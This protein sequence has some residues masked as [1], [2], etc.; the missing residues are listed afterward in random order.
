LKD[1]LLVDMLCDALRGPMER[2]AIDQLRIGGDYA[3]L[4]ARARAKR[5]ALLAADDK[6]D[7]DDGGLGEL[8]A[9]AWYFGER[10][11]AQLPNDVGAYA[12]RLGFKEGTAFRRAVL[13]EFRFQRL[14]GSHS[15]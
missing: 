10:F 7:S 1:E 15:E 8:N 14:K 5:S 3:R 11:G 12:A 13:D 9:I 6:G 2:C 4:L